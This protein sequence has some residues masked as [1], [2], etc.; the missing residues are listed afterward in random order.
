MKKYY[1]GIYDPSAKE[2]F[3]LGL[4]CTEG[5]ETRTLVYIV[6]PCH[7]STVLAHDLTMYETLNE[8]YFILKN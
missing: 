8:A 2:D 7:C 1:G 6:M 5:E 3:F 4:F